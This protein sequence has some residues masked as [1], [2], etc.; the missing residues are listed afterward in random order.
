M[1]RKHVCHG[2]K[3]PLLSHLLTKA[4][5]GA[6]GA[7]VGMQAGSLPAGVLLIQWYLQELDH[8]LPTALWIRYAGIAM[9]EQAVG[10]SSG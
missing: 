7:T 6:L 9:P 2:E 10:P 8:T 3:P 4:L 5:S 1:F